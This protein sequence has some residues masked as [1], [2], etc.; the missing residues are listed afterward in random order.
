M[1]CSCCG[2]QEKLRR[3][4]I[5]T[6]VA[7]F[8]NPQAPVVCSDCVVVWY[9]TGIIDPVELRQEVRRRREAGERM[10]Q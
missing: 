5:M 4:P 3:C 6:G 2:G 8:D 9:T 1:E 10:H 7:G